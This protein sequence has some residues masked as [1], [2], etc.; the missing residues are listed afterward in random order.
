HQGRSGLPA[1][2][3]QPGRGICGKGP[4]RSR[5]GQAAGSLEATLQLAFGRKFSRPAE[6][7]IV[8]TLPERPKVS[9]CGARDG[10]LESSRWSA[11]EVL[12]NLAGVRNRR[13][14]TN[15][16]CNDQCGAT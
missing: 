6:G 12:C 11:A 7:F 9:R 4:A 15:G 5:A 3:L 14:T 10:V 2:L 8:C 13:P 16:Q 1:L